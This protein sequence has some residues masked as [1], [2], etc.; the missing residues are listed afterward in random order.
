[1]NGGIE[2]DATS[3]LA[4]AP[5]G[6]TLAAVEGELLGSGLTLDVHGAKESSETVADWLA[7]GARGARSA[8]LDPADHQVAGVDMTLH[9]GRT[10]HV[11]P[12]PR[13]AVGPDLI[14]LV[15]GMG[16]R[17][18]KVDHAWLRVHPIG[19]VRPNHGE[20]KV[21]LDPPVGQGEARLLHAIAARLESK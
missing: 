16:E 17:F 18:A 1:V 15:V 13:R 19:A 7:A 3:L 5:G 6:M 11:R 20:L 8:W 9:D 12:A 14:A 21:D 10:V 4:K 2:L